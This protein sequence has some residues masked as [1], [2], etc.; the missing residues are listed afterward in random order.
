[1]PDIGLH[2]SFEATVDRDRSAPALAFGDEHVTYGELE[3]RSNRLANHLRTRGVGRGDVVGVCL[4]RS[5]ALVTAIVAVLKAG[6]AYLPLDPSLPT[7]RLRFMAT[8]ADARV[9]ITRD[10]HAAAFAELPTVHVDE[11]ASLIERSAATRPSAGVGGRDLAYV[12]FTSGSTGKPKA[13]AVEHRSVVN[14]VLAQIDAFGIGT[15]SRVLQFASIGFDASVSEIFTALTAG[16]TLCLG[17]GRAFTNLDELQRVLHGQGVTLATLPPTVLASI[18]SH[19]WP[20]LSTVVSAGERCSAA[21][22]DRWSTGRRFLNAYGPTEAAVCATVG[23]CHAGAGEP[24]IGRPIRNVRV[25]VL[26]PALQP[27]APGVPGEIYLGGEGVA[28]GY[29]GNP[30]LTAERFVPDPFAVEPGGRLYRTGDRARRRED[31]DLEFLGR[32]DRQVKLRGYRLELDEL[33]LALVGEEAIREAAVELVRGG[34]TEASIVAYVVA[35]RSTEAAPLTDRLL[36]DRLAHTLPD[37]MLPSRLVWLD[38]LPRLSSGKIDR[39]ALP[40]TPALERVSLG[41]PATT[42]TER[43][44]ARVWQ[45]LGLGSPG[46]EDDFFE[47]GGHSMLVVK[48]V[49]AIERELGVDL[50]IAAIFAASRLGDLAAVIDRARTG[51]APSPAPAID[52]VA[53]ATLD[54]DIAPSGTSPAAKTPEHLLV[55]GATGFVGSSL[56]AELLA[57]TT[58]QITCLVRANPAQGWAR[59]RERLAWFEVLSSDPATNARLHV[60]EGDLRRPQLGLEDDD[61]AALADTVDSIVHAGAEV[62][63]VYPYEALVAANV[64]GTREILRLA[65]RGRPKVVHY[66]STLSL[67]DA[68]PTLPEDEWP[69]AAGIDTRR[70][71]EATKWV[72][73]RLLRAARERGIPCSLY[74]IGR[75]GG[76]ST[77]GTANSDDLWFQ[78]IEGCVK[79]GA[80]PQ[81]SLALDLAPVD[82]IAR[83]VVRGITHGDPGRSFHVVGPRVAW[84]RV[85]TALRDYGYP[86]VAVPFEEWIRRAE[87]VMSEETSALAPFVLAHRRTSSSLQG[88]QE[89][90][91]LAEHAIDT[92]NLTRLLEGTETQCPEIDERM[93]HMTF[94]YLVRAGLFF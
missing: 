10:D 12:I 25:Y 61:F 2:D 23:E 88:Q 77:R 29:L 24:S 82:Y 17:D 7:S 89:P 11:H 21:I 91:D 81:S 78:M 54:P 69:D 45:E 87:R 31:G 47:R 41:R 6:A 22:V 51:R 20:E 34:T 35:N 8:E 49:H 37:Y 39:S 52:L 27:A 53:E 92:R 50:P 71:Y 90:S 16:A 76:H 30:S 94:S 19:G 1:M 83:A 57:R 26:D 68:C 75:V 67:L 13:V 15:T 4:E 32:S 65:A 9:V 85:I 73:E 56:V 40:T 18:P 60:V 44:L 63:L 48:L 84:D 38:A 43:A 59:L 80:A 28:R 86:V 66:V 55:T 14:L 79:L 64:G 74:R 42:D 62:N 93:L 36:R 58:A 5:P 46:A 3:E 70:G 33:E 72:S